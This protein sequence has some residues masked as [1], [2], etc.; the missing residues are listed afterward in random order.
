M[1][2]P[3]LQGSGVYDKYQFVP[4]AEEQVDETKYT[5]V[6]GWD[7]KTD[8]PDPICAHF[9][10]SEMHFI[11]AVTAQGACI[12]GGVTK[13]LKVQR[14][15]LIGGGV[16][17]FAARVKHYRANDSNKQRF[18]WQAACLHSHNHAEGEWGHFPGWCSVA[19]RLY[20]YNIFYILRPLSS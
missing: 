8:A 16:R 12:K 14:T 15:R 9:L 20:I 18:L 4:D 6:H 10:H 5:Q 3:F 13:T 2:L 17:G 11:T 7:T 1:A 19:Q